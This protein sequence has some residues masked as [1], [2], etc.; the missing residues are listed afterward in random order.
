MKHRYLPQ[1]IRRY[2]TAVVGEFET[3]YF[4]DFHR[5][6]P[7]EPLRTKVSA[8]PIR[9]AL[10]ERVPTLGLMTF[11]LRD[12]LAVTVIFVKNWRRFHARHTAWNKLTE[13]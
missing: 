9:S 10:M 11:L 7:T 5:E 1:E 13:P 6:F 3:L 4:E 8:S 2:T 12:S